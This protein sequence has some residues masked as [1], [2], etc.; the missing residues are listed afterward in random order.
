MVCHLLLIVRF[1]FAAHLI[2]DEIKIIV[3]YV[4]R[5]KAF[6]CLHLTA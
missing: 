6:V 5:D 1:Q 4:A 2:E 3:L